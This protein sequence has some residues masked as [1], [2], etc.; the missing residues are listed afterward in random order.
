MEDPTKDKVP[1]LEYYPILQEYE[2]ACGQFLVFPPKRDTNLSIDLMHGVAP[3]C[4][5]PNR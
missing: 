2:D 1:S 5:A 3:T 4:K